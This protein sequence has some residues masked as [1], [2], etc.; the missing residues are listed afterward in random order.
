MPR[1][2]L[3]EPVAEIQWKGWEGDLGAPTQGPRERRPS[4]TTQAL[5]PHTWWAE[6]LCSPGSKAMCK[7]NLW[8][9]GS[10]SLQ[11]MSREMSG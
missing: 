1:S 8:V 10:I 7:F 2:P 11:Q 6:G 4:Y 3:R 5:Q 9:Y